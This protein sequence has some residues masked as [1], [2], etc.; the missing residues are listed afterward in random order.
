MLGI[1]NKEGKWVSWWLGN[2]MLKAAEQ[3]VVTFQADGDELNLFLQAMQATR[4]LIN[5]VGY[6]KQ[7]GFFIGGS[8]ENKASKAIEELE[9]LPQGKPDS[10]EPLSTESVPDATGTAYD[11]APH[12]SNWCPDVSLDRITDQRVSDPDPA[13]DGPE[14]GIC[15]Y[16]EPN[17]Q[18]ELELQKVINRR[19]RVQIKN[20]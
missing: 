9:S 18:I 11:G 17:G 4:D 12:G 16:Y 14:V 8:E 5:R 2:P 15:K 20:R 6:S 3:R 13:E 19:K 7:I 1:K 10:L